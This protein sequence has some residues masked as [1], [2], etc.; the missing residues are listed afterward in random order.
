MKDGQRNWFVLVFCLFIIN[1][2]FLIML[3]HY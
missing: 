3:V 2:S 1:S